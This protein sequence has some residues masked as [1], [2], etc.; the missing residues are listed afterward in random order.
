MLPIEYDDKT[1]TVVQELV[2]TNFGIRDELNAAA[3]S[4]D[5]E[6]RQRV[7]RRLA[8]FLANNAIRLQQMLAAS[9][10]E[11]AEPLDIDAIVAA[12]FKAVKVR[13]G[14]AGV[15]EAAEETQ[16][17]LKRGYDRAIEEASEPQAEG[18]LREQRKQVEFSEQ[19]LRSIKPSQDPSQ[20]KKSNHKE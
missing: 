9:G 14:T 15:I 19:V 1:L 2:E 20:T 5:D 8:D 6:D 4:V 11:P 17:D 10:N 16:R 12:L 3:D 7:C 13:H 18:V